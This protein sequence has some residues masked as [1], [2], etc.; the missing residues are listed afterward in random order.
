M[1]YVSFLFRQARS[2][3]ILVDARLADD[4]LNGV[5]IRERPRQRLD[6][7]AGHTLTAC[8]IVEHHNCLK[9]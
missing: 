4:A 2:P 9:E 3:V 8:I 1:I 6:H 7:N 5:I